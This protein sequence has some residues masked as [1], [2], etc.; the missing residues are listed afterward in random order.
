[1]VVCVMHYERD[2]GKRRWKNNKRNP[3]KSFI[4]DRSHSNNCKPVTLSIKGVDLRVN[5]S[6]DTFIHSSMNSINK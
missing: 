6:V 3:D 4:A 2:R 5:S 1:M